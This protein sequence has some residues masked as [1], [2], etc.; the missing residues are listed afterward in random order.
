MLPELYMQGNGFATDCIRAV[1]FGILFQTLVA[2]LLSET[3]MDCS[4]I[5][6][7]SMLTP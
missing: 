4:L 2:G 3:V 1:P 6:L 7:R 5:S